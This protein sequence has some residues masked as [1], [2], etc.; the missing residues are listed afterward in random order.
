M[1]CYEKLQINRFNAE[2][3]EAKEEVVAT[4]EAV[5]EEPPAEEA[6]PDEPPAEEGYKLQLVE[7][8]ETPCRIYR[9]LLGLSLSLFSVAFTVTI[10]FPFNQNSYTQIW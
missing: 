10:P 1:N 7:S 8:K 9:I 2:E 5:P 4:E 6:P 3:E